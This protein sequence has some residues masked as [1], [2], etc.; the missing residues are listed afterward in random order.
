MHGGTKLSCRHRRLAVREAWAS[1]AHQGGNAV[2]RFILS[3]DERTP[4]VAA[5]LEAHNDMIFVQVSLSW[6]ILLLASFCGTFVPAL[7]E[8]RLLPVQ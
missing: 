4:Q 1:T 2:V 5:E 8:S 6:T 7:S 3:E